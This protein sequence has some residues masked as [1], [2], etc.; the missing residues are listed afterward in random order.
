MASV[1][2]GS[3]ALGASEIQALLDLDSEGEE[4]FA[5]VLGPAT[6]EA[7]DSSDN[8]EQHTDLLVPAAEPVRFQPCRSKRK[9]SSLEAS[10]DERNF[11]PID[12]PRDVQQHTAELEKASGKKI[13]QSFFFLHAASMLRAQCMRVHLRFASWHTLVIV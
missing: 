5:D 1:N 9:V 4:D 6:E 11:R 2:V 7:S 10:L 12:L 3:S 8:D 13:P